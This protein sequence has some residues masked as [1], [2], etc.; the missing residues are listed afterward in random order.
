[1]N[2]GISGR[3]PADDLLGQAREGDLDAFAVPIEEHLGSIV[4]GIAWN[5]FGD[6][7]MAEELAQ[8]VFLQLYRNLAAIQSRSHLVYWLRQVTSRKCIDAA[9]RRGPKRVVSL[10]EVELTV[11]P[12]PAD[13]FLARRIRERIAALPD[14]QRIVLT[15]RYQEEVGPA[16]I[17][18]LLGMP[19]NTIKSCLHRALTTLREEFGGES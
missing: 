1:V 13:P 5:F 6:R 18:E 17:A 2:D 12:R 3:A 8:D 14:M 11:T 16:E 19:E 10:D 7:S 4:Y 9:R 15:L